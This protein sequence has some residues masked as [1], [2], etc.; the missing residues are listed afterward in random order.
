MDGTKAAVVAAGADADAR[1]AF[2]R[3]VPED[4]AGASIFSMFLIALLIK[5]WIPYED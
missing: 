1:V 4:Q 5:E 2:S 3:R